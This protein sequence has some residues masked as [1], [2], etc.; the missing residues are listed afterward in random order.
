VHIHFK[1]RAKAKS[2]RSYDFTSQ[3]YFDDSIT[4]RVHAHK[5]YASKGQRTLKNDG[6]GIFRNGGRQL[7]LSLLDGQGYAATFD[8]GLQIA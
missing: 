1:V 6:D 8:L 7:M 2:G 4:D 3:L 5:P